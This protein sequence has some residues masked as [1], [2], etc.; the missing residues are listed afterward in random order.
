MRTGDIEVSV[1]SQQDSIRASGDSCFQPG[2]GGLMVITDQLHVQQVA[3]LCDPVA[4]ADIP[5]IHVE[6][7]RP[8]PLC[9]QCL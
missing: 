2:T 3:L 4:Q 6:S 8:A 5:V 7:T 9:F 1:L